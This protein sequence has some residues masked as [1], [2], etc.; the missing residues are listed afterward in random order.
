M[1][2]KHIG[3]IDT[4]RMVGIIDNDPCG[5][6]YVVRIP[7]KYAHSDI[8]FNDTNENDAAFYPRPKKLNQKFG[9]LVANTDF[10]THSI[11]Q[12]VK[13]NVFVAFTKSYVKTDACRLQFHS[14]IGFELT[15]RH[16]TVKMINRDMYPLTK[17]QIK[18]VE[19]CD[20]RF[21]KLTPQEIIE[22]EQFK[23][24]RNKEVAF[25]F[26]ATNRK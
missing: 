6:L 23:A 19:E 15:Q 26:K 1:N 11:K 21:Q 5:T 16:P 4:S 9:V 2:S 12:G 10:D 7:A 24:K 20:D 14:V 25:G 17:Q 8:N 13:A 18:Q 22:I 3:K